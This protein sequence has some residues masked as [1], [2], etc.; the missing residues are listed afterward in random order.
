MICISQ[1]RSLSLVT[2]SQALASGY[3]GSDLSNSLQT[4]SFN[5]LLDVFHVPYTLSFS[6][7]SACVCEH[8]ACAMMQSLWRP[9]DPPPPPVS[10]SYHLVVSPGSNLSCQAFTHGPSTHCVI[11][12]TP[13]SYS[14]CLNTHNISKDPYSSYSL[15]TTI[16]PGAEARNLG[17]GLASFLSLLHPVNSKVPLFLHQSPPPPPAPSMVHF[18]SGPLTQLQM[19][20]AWTIASGLL[21]G[22]PP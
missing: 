11:S 13:S 12:P 6:Y 19:I 16:L 20:S 18:F 22:S 14:K 17:I 15:K 10:S 8:H 3:L 21:A 7:F 9:E 2:F 1:L 4:C 5:S